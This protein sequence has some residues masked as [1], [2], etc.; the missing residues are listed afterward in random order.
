MKRHETMKF[1]LA[2]IGLGVA[3]LTAACAPSESEQI[4]TIT[5]IAAGIIA[6]QTAQ[7]P[8]ATLT[9]TVT[10]VTPTP[11]LFPGATRISP[12]DGMTMVHIP[13]GEYTLGSS[14]ADVDWAMEACLEFFN[15]CDSVK[16]EDEMPQH[17]VWLDPYWIDQTEIT[18]SMFAQFVAETGYIT[19]AERFQYS[20]VYDRGEW[21]QWRG[22]DW[23]DTDV[24]HFESIEDNPV[25]NVSWYD[26]LAYCQ[27]AG[28]RLPTEAE[29]EAAARGTDLRIFPWGDEK[30]GDNH[31]NL[32]DHSISGTSWRNNEVDDGSY[33]IAPVWRY[34]LGASPFGVLGMAGNVKEWVYDGYAPGYNLSP[35]EEN[36]VNTIDTEKRVCRGGSYAS[37]LIDARVANRRG[38]DPVEGISDYGFRCAFSSRTLPDPP[39]KEPLPEMTLITWRTEV[40]T[41]LDGTFTREDYLKSFEGLEITG[42]YNQCSYLRITS[43]DYE[44]GWLRVDDDIVLYKDCSEFEE[45]FIRP[46]SDSWK[47]GYSGSGTLTVKNQAETDTFLVLVNGE[48]DENYRMYVRAGEQVTMKYIPDGVYDV[49]LTSGTIWVAYK[50]R[51]K[52]A[53]SYEKLQEPLEF[54][55]TETTASA[56]E[57]VL[58][59]AEGN[60]DSTAIDESD[61]PSP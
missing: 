14:Q 51:F 6:T 25:V 1:K 59:T 41:I 10:P 5:Q 60:T 23:A 35:S 12:V 17:T 21:E 8:T 54:A 20:Y 57:L 49:F 29:W 39:A 43:P 7:A 32:A 36:P 48:A 45:F 52:D 40:Y 19:D 22:V 44:E 34:P 61:F 2:L 47:K 26:A 24:Y 18:Y 28:R 56:W 9:P 13:A 3:M 37:A 30:P 55:S 4:A 27:W 15:E 16:F 46:P 58:E 53:I 33:W 38:I 11:T 31:A 50:E 42:Q